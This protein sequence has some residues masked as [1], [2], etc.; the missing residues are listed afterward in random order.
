M[1]FQSL[2]I[3]LIPMLIL[4]FSCGVLFMILQKKKN[5]NSSGEMTRVL[6]AIGFAGGF[7]ISTF[8]LIDLISENNGDVTAKA[9]P[10]IF[11]IFI[12]LVMLLHV[13]MSFRSK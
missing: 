6:C 2:L 1:A 7:F 9:V 10:Y 11:G 8:L 12:Y 5:N 3:L 4:I 13:L